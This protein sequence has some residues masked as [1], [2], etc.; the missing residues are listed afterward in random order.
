MSCRFVATNRPRVLP[1]R[2]AADCPEWHPPLVVC[3]GCQPC[4]QTHCEV[5][6]RA[7]IPDGTACATCVGTVRDNLDAIALMSDTMLAEAIVKGLESEA[8]HLAGPTANPE[9]WRQRRRFGYRDR[10]ETRPD[11]N[12]FRPDVLGEE[13]P[14]WV[15]GTWDMLV[16]EHL[17][18]GHRTARI[19][20]ETAVAYLKANLT[21]LARDEEF[22]FAELAREVRACESHLERVLHDG[23]QCDTGAPCMACSVPLVRVWGDDEQHDGW[24]CPRCRERSTDAQY[25]FAVKHLHREEADWLTDRDMEMRTGVK[26]GTVRKWAERGEVGRRRDSG[27]TVY[28]VADVLGRVGLAS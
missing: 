21:D 18:H 4:P 19:T 5:C 12:T 17:E 28:C 25:R 9:Q 6:H 3:G 27:R 10:I 8:A 24:M 23:E 26:A 11:G 20:V 2:H 1:E 22:P 15:L 16:T 7:H 13:H 14:L